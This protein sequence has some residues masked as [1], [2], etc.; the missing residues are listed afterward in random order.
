MQTNTK[1]QNGATQFSLS[2]CAARTDKTLSLFRTFAQLLTVRLHEK[3]GKY[4]HTKLNRKAEQT[5][6]QD[7]TE[8][9][10]A[11][12]RHTTSSSQ[13]C[14]NKKKRV[15]KIT[16]RAIDGVSRSNVIQR[17]L[18]IVKHIKH[19]LFVRPHCNCLTNQNMP[20]C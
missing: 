1:S 17:L 13:K 10:L 2:P 14:T 7:S 12:P 3:V 15:D 11:G 19:C 6:N 20:V 8:F 5:E 18:L 16:N 9:S 4:L